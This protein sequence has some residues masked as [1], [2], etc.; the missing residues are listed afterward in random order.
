[1]SESYLCLQQDYL[2]D[3]TVG[4]ITENAPREEAKSI[5]MQ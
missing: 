3:I 4:S 1:M 5:N 2:P